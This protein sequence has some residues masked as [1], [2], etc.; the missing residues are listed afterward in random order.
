MSV[1]TDL[2]E[3]INHICALA[4]VEDSIDI[5][6][7]NLISLISEYEV[8]SYPVILGQTF[9]RQEHKL[10][11]FWLITDKQDKYITLSLYSNQQ[12]LISRTLN[13]S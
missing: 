12:K 10:G 8:F 5:T 11:I 3:F 6:K 7:A 13:I 4:Y 1:L 2:D 9:L